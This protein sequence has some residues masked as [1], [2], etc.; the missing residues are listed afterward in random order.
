MRLIGSDKSEHLFPVS[1]M[2]PIELLVHFFINWNWDLKLQ[3]NEFL[4]SSK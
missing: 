4:L 2:I 1:L 3:H